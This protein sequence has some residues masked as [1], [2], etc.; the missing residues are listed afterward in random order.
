MSH[1]SSVTAALN[2]YINKNSKGPAPVVVIE[3]GYFDSRDV[4]PPDDRLLHLRD[5]FWLLDKLSRLT[6]GQPR[7]IVLSAFF[8]DLSTEGR[9]CGIDLCRDEINTVFADAGLKI[10][11]RSP[12]SAIPQGAI[13]IYHRHGIEEDESKYQLYFY[14]MRTTR[15]RALSHLK[16]LI[17]SPNASEILHQ[18]DDGDVIDIRLKRKPAEEIVL[19]SRRKGTYRMSVRC[20]ALMA[21]HY[22]DIY[23]RSAKYLGDGSP[24]WIFDFNR[25]TERDRV[26]SGAKASFDLYNWPAPL[27]VEVV[28]CIY[29]PKVNDAIPIF[30]T[31]KP[32]F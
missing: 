30:V 25:F 8:N 15:N 32:T 11:D 19:G 29:Y 14:R 6:I 20:T 12:F 1:S 21:Q 17:Q 24:L 22:W 7:M 23:Q 9:Y 4:E 2:E 26:H 5:S 27:K 18:V 28:N 16:K 3:G 13:P 31:E 10:K